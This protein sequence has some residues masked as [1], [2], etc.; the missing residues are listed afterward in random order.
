MT[1]VSEFFG[2]EIYQD[3]S[4]IVR[5]MGNDLVH[6]EMYDDFGLKRIQKIQGHS[7]NFAED[8][9]ENWVLGVIQD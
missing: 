4:A 7:I 5:D 2:E 9:A 6:V 1:I 3:R 8:C